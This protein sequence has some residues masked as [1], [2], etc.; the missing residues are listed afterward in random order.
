MATS[1]GSPCY[2][3]PELVISEGL[4]V[5]SAVDIWSCG[6]ILY[7]MLSG[8]LPY[9]DDPAN[10]D[11]DN[12]NLLYKY[13][14]STRLNFPEHTS[15]QAKHLM[16]IMLVPDPDQRCKIEDIMGHPWLA[17]Y[18][19]LFA[20]TVDVHESL[21]MDNLSR[22]NELAR[23]ELAARRQVQKDAQIAKT[24]LARSQST[25]PG[26]TTSMIDYN[27]RNKDARPQ[28]ALPGTTTMPEYLN[29]AGHRTPPVGHRQPLSVPPA[30]LAAAQTS[31]VIA[32]AAILSP[33]SAM[34]GPPMAPASWAPGPSILQA[35]APRPAQTTRSTD[36]DVDVGPT[37][38]PLVEPL[39]AGG[40]P[41]MAANKNR[42][43]IQVEYDGDASYERFK[44]M[45]EA[46]RAAV[47]I[48]GASIPVFP[49][50][51]TETSSTTPRSP[52]AVITDVTTSDV[53][54]EYDSSDQDN[55]QEGTLDSFHDVPSGDVTPEASQVL[56]PTS[57]PKVEDEIKEEVTPTMPSV[58][59]TPSK[60][61]KVGEAPANVVSPSTPK[62]T[63]IDAGDIAT[64]KA[65]PKAPS[66]TP[67]ATTPR[68]GGK[69]LNSMP[70]QLASVPVMDKTSTPSKE[71]NPR[72]NSMGLP[73][74]PPAGRERGRKGMSLDKFGLA[75][76]LGQASAS[77]VDVSR[78]PPSSGRAAAS[79][80]ESREEKE[81]VLVKPKRESVAPAR[82]DSDDKKTR[83]KT[84]HDMVKR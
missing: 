41:T 23:R 25:M 5:G 78:P 18:G 83:R 30:V 57:A 52:P 61:A 60:K 45:A 63:Q 33:S 20:R 79:I 81:N 36:M 6:V 50:P 64:P 58:P 59:Q 38:A 70:A 47:A 84:L 2:A 65:P 1:C 29:N 75:R 51:R 4:Y 7:A 39:G 71:R 17:G 24:N 8:Y 54:M 53:E 16:Q 27:R 67:V 82:E 35:A 21:F 19:E 72:L 76:L 62:A 69:R 22:R 48:G 68:A 40:R 26:V 3:A 9:D 34:P 44:E 15:P 10:P 13:I 42:H 66:P 37:Q 56:P 32:D 43:T 11:G 74:P 12:I 14:M 49:P 73:N 55:T 77:S 28:T 31:P 46:K 80:Q